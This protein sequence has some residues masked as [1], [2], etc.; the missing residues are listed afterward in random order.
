MHTHICAMM[1]VC[2]RAEQT[3]AQT[4]AH[5]HRNPADPLEWIRVPHLI[6]SLYFKHIYY[7]CSCLCRWVCVCMSV[8]KNVT[9]L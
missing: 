9:N 6:H 5:K 2:A 1:S 3:N 8:S 4:A 7:R